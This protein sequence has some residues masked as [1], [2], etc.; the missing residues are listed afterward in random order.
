VPSSHDLPVLAEIV[1]P[2]CGRKDFHPA[3]TPIPPCP[4]CRAEQHVVDTF[5]DRRRVD[6]PVK[7]DRRISQPGHQI[8]PV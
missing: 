7:N 2:S 6:A 8:P 3:L 5:R 4:N 1:C